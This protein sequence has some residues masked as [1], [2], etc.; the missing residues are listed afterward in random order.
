MLEDVGIH[1]YEIWR[2]G[3]P[4]TVSS[5]AP[6]NRA[7]FKDL[8]F[9]SSE[10]DDAIRAISNSSA[11]V[12][13]C[14]KSVKQRLGQIEEQKHRQCLVFV[15]NPRL[16][17]MHIINLVYKRKKS[18]LRAVSRSAIV[19]KTVKI[20][21]NCSIGEYS[22]IGNNCEIGDNTTIHDRVSILQNTRIGRNCIIQPGVVIG[23]DGFAY[24]RLP[25]TME[26]ERFPHIGGVQIGDNVEICSNCSI[27]RGSLSDTV[28]GNGTK[29]NALV[30]IAHN[31]EIGRNCACS[32]GAVIGGS[33]LIG[34]TCWLGQNSTLKHKI[35]IGN[36]VIVGSGASVINN[37][38][39]EDIVAGVPAKSIKYKVTTNQLFLMGGHA[40]KRKSR[41]IIM[42]KQFK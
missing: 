9:C 16:T 24:E 5:I 11:G 7:C 19:S 37:V 17:I 32:A 27:V 25:E 39:D 35:R 28:I 10:G 41:H 20:G 13:L 42:N 4:I 23:A 8:S 6:I 21:K 22:V 12:I 34:D 15:D 36:K 26:L 3:S 29:I 33:T 31:V 2:N 40:H 30:H 38:E 14:N 1:S 18:E